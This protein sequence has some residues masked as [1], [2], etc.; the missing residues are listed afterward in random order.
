MVNTYPNSARR[1]VYNNLMPSK[2]QGFTSIIQ[3]KGTMPEFSHTARMKHFPDGA[4][5]GSRVSVSAFGKHPSHVVLKVCRYKRFYN[6]RH[7]GKKV[8]G[9]TG[10]GRIFP[11]NGI[12]LSGRSV[13]VQ[14]PEYPV[15]NDAGPDC[16]TCDGIGMMPERSPGGSDGAGCCPHRGLFQVFEGPGDQ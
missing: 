12:A 14:Q 9:N 13:P 16:C 8:H 3:K 2:C 5:S 15:Q 4:P 6:G 7:K 1:R 11:V 10:P